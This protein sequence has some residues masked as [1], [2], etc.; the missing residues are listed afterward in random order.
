MYKHAPF[1]IHCNNTG[2]FVV[3]K[4]NFIHRTVFYWIIWMDDILKLN[5]AFFRLLFPLNRTINT[6][7][8]YTCVLKMIP[9][10]KSG[11][12]IIVIDL[13]T[14][15]RRMRGYDFAGLFTCIV[16]HR[17]T[18]I[19]GCA[20]QDT[21]TKDFNSAI[22]NTQ[23]LHWNPWLINVICNCIRTLR[24]ASTPV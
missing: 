12:R 2:Y 6:I 23:L 4:R 17:M 1:I 14:Q 21:C 16:V 11:E 20:K 18:V 22:M 10:I 7:L 13:N 9:V 8:V 19:C 5:V 24:R 15:Q 3:A